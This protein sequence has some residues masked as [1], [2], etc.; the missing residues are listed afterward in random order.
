MGSFSHITRPN[1]FS[2]TITKKDLWF[3]PQVFSLIYS[4]NLQTLLCKSR[5]KHRPT[6]DRNH[7]IGKI[8]F[9][10]ISH[11]FNFFYV[12][13]TYQSRHRYPDQEHHKPS[14]SATSLTTAAY[15]SSFPQ[16]SVCSM[17]F[18]SNSDLSGAASAL[19]SASV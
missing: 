11:L 3:S 10:S 16:M 1:P 9:P 15:P 18:N 12:W 7:K 5:H 4:R 17:P 8:S 13:V 14:H 19:L 2:I 6:G